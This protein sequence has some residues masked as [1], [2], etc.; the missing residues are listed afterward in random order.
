MEYF[1]GKDRLV[2][3]ND[4]FTSFVG[5]VTIEYSFNRDFKY[6]KDPNFRSPFTREI[7]SF[8]DMI[9]PHARRWGTY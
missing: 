7:R 8:L 5:D 6:L 4:M 9:H 3:L 1:A 2:S